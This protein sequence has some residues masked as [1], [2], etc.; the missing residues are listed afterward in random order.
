MAFTSCTAWRL[1]DSDDGILA[2]N[3]AYYA[4]SGEVTL[5]TSK[6]TWP[7]SRLGVLADDLHIY[8][9]ANFIQQFREAAGEDEEVQRL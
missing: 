4:R 3:R 7:I 5:E 2:L 8:V 1:Y 9:L 6:R